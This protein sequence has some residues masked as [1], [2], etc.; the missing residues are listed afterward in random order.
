VCVYAGA[1]MCVRVGECVGVWGR[2][3]VYVSVYDG[4][5]EMRPHTSHVCDLHGG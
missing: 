4:T 1:K 3:C 2:M 5:H